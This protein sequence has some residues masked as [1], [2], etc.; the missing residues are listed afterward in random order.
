MVNRGGALDTI[1]RIMSEKMTKSQAGR[2]G[3]ANRLRNTTA[4]QRKET[5][6][7]GGLARAASMTHEQRVALGKMGG[8]PKKQA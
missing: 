3:A 7:L 1:G 8:R 5:A 6:R 2:I 4:E